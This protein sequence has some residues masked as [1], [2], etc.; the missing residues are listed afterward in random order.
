MGKLVIDQKM[1]GSEFINVVFREVAKLAKEKGL[2]KNKIETEL[3]VAPT[4]NDF[5]SVIK[6]YFG[7]ELVINLNI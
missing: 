3:T 5:K 7:E 1:L 6:T 4:P 2:D